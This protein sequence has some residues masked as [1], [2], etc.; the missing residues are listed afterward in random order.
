SGGAGESIFTTKTVSLGSY[1]GTSL[2]LRFNY[3]AP[4]S[5]QSYFP[6]VGSDIG[7]HFDDITITNA[8][9]LLTPVTNGIASPNFQF[10]PPQAGNFNLEARGVIFADFPLSWGPTK[11]VVA[12]TS[13][14]PVIAINKLSVS[15]NQAKVDFS[16]QA[17]LASTYK[18]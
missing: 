5:G 8:E 12:I 4:A 9:Q 11:Q 1:A 18:L 10:N 6:Q 7:W 2:L 14:A 13:A 15:N 17:G 3:D 16:L